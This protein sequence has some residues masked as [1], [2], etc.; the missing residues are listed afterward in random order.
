MKHGVNLAKDELENAY[1][2]GFQYSSQIIASENYR[3]VET[4]EIVDKVLETAGLNGPPDKDEL[5]ALYEEACMLDPPNLKEG[6]VETLEAI[7]SDYRL[8]LISVTGV[9]PGRI[10]RKFLKEHHIYHYFDGFVFSDEVGYVKPS[11]KLFQTALDLFHVQPHET[12]HVGD[13][14]KGDIVGAKNLGITTVWVKTRN[15][16][17]SEEKNP[18]YTIKRLPELLNVLDILKTQY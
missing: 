1:Q 2:A 14:L 12:I 4:I 15:Q 10:I 8:G 18:D 17:P 13:S 6:V 3:H 9:S 5:V 11:S 16:E 7:Y